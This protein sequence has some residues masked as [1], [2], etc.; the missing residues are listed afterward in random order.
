MSK[1]DNI[2][3]LVTFLALALSHKI[4]S[5]VNQNELYAG[6]YKKEYDTYLQQAKEIAFEENFNYYDKTEIKEKLTKKL[7]TEL[8]KRD[9]IDNK[10]FDLIEGEVNNALST[11]NLNN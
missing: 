2:L 5:Q 1:K 7:R 9:F 6:K 11:L 3:K 4:G 10:K 8:E